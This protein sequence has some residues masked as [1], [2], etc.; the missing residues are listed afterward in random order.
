MK[1]TV[2]LQSTAV[3]QI[4]DERTVSINLCL[5]DYEGTAGDA[6]RYQSYLSFSTR[7]QDHDTYDTR[8]LCSGTQGGLVVWKLHKFQFE[9]VVHGPQYGR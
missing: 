5:G 7:D 6:L 9:W 4:A 2:L 1:T 3:F 8:K